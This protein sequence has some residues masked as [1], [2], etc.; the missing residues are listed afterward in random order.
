M[1]LSF[2]IFLGVCVISFIPVIKDHGETWKEYKCSSHGKE[3]KMF[4]MQLFAIWATPLFTAI[5]TMISGIEA[6][7][8]ERENA[9]LHKEA[10]DAIER[11]AIAQSNSLVL[12]S[13]TAALERQLLET[14]TN[15]AEMDP[16]RQPIRSIE[17]SAVFFVRGTNSFKESLPSYDST[18]FGSGFLRFLSSKTNV[19]D[20]VLIG[21]KPDLSRGEGD[22][23]IALR[24]HMPAGS[25]RILAGWLTVEDSEC[26]D[27]IR[28]SP[29]FFLRHN[30][31]IIRGWVWVTINNATDK[32]YYIPHQVFGFPPHNMAILGMVTNSLQSSH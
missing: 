4:G 17:A 7:S 6:V 24:S 12:R 11:A 18:S 9:I 15:V 8:S 21:D 23:E 3:R 22:V 16:R 13:N 10:A 1:P 2:W 32:E 5:A 26:W 20:A 14:R 25:A 19:N 30:S 27:R 28:L 31:E 29:W